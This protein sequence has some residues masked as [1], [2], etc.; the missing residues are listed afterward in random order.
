MRA[1]PAGSTE[2]MLHS[3]MIGEC[4]SCLGR[5]GERQGSLTERYPIEGSRD[6]LWR[7][8]AVSEPVT[9]RLDGDLDVD[10][11][12]IGA[13]FTGL[14]A[15]L[16]LA[17]AGT[18]AAVLE[19][20]HLGFGASGRSG[21][22]VN[23]GLNLGPSA[24]IDL[25]GGEAGERMI[26]TIGRVPDALFDLIRRHG[27]DCDPVQNGWVQGAAT[28][29]QLRSQAE[30]AKDYARHGIRFD[31]LDAGE[32]FSR[33]GA[34]GYQGGL[35]CPSAG[36]IHPLSYTR[37]L[38]RVVMEKG[39]RLFTKA[40]VD[41]LRKEGTRWELVTEGGRV[42]A[43][44]VL[45]CTNAY[46]D[47]LIPGLKETLVPVRS[48]LMAS[49]PLS[50][51][52]RAKVMPGEVTFVDKRR[53][54][55]YMRYDRDGRLCAGDHGPMRDG[56]ALDDY[57]AV[58]R[59]VVATFPDLAD[60]SWDFHWGGRVAMTR[61]KLPFIQVIDQGLIAGMGYNGRGVG[62]GSM[63]GRL[64]A[65]FALGKDEKSL[66]FP[67]TTPKTFSFHRFHRLGASIAIKWHGLMDRWEARRPIG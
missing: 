40:K 27:L 21:G 25:F 14:N 44:T 43:K 8:T 26:Q 39:V 17:E 2:P 67:V 31:V 56:F 33:S 19:A 60:V 45:I 28:S 9:E 15:A 59:R 57:E 10:V 51:N 36:S 16:A 12:I 52:L 62:M 48:V 5:R 42:R 34:H 58:K 29:G 63:M 47:G 37:E 53:L 35:F 23:L 49:E 50:P 13:G 18:S 61:S 46:T 64:L 4:L 22:Q 41:Q 65:D 24:L 55:L 66:P 1:P 3:I 7:A 32:V 30:L 54:I 11:A 6:A 20:A 38:A